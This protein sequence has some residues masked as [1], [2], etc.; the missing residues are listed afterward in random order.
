M[1]INPSLYSLMVD[2]Q[3]QRMRVKVCRHIPKQSN[4]IDIACGTGA[5]A[6]HLAEKCRSITGIDIW[7]PM[8]NYAE[9]KRQKLN[10]P[11]LTFQI[12]DANDL[13]HFKDKEFDF[14]IMSLALHQFPPADRI[15]IM[16]EAVRISKKMI[17]ADYAT[18]LPRNIYGIG[19]KIVERLAGKQHFLNFKSYISAGGL[20]GIIKEIGLKTLHIGVFGN[21][22]FV[23]GI[24]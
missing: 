8:I 19:T 10:I 15:R 2:T 20:S 4:V 12:A 5:Q 9:K 11:N 16:K 24:F 17:I 1:N 22:V 14:S 3:V 6:F 18:P 23:L 21:E 13:S 7:E